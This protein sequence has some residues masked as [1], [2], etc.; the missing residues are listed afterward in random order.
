MEIPEPTIAYEVDEGKTH[1]NLAA[2]EE[3]KAYLAKLVDADDGFSNEDAEASLQRITA[4]ADLHAEARL[5]KALEYEFNK[6]G[7][8]QKREADKRKAQL[9]D[10][11]RPR[12]GTGPVAPSRLNSR[13]DPMGNGLRTRAEDNAVTKLIGLER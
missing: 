1:T 11:Q 2:L 3:Y 7:R 12:S 9:A 5:A 10:A 8:E 6:A 4:D 13:N